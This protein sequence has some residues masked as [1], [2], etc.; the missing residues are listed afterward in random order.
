MRRLADALKGNTTLEKLEM[1]NTRATDRM[2]K[3]KSKRLMYFNS[4]FKNYSIL[5]WSLYVTVILGYN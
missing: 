1:A 4:N 2:A 5:L 3:V